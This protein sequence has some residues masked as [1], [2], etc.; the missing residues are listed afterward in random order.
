MN[1]EFLTWYNYYETHLKRMYRIILNE[2]KRNNYKIG[3]KQSYTS[4]CYLIYN[5]SSKRIPLY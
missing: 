5:N 2:M 4:F 3:E 1:K